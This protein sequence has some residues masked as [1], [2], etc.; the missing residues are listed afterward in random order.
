[1]KYSGYNSPR[2]WDLSVCPIFLALPF[3]QQVRE[4]KAILMLRHGRA[5][6]K[7]VRGC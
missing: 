3:Q 4:F 6:D 1:V 2:R 7:H 5:G